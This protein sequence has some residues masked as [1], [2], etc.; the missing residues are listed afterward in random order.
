MNIRQL[1]D[2]VPTAG[3]RYFSL[4]GVPINKVCFRVVISAFAIRAQVMLVANVCQDNREAHSGQSMACK[5][6]ALDDGSGRLAA[7]SYEVGGGYIFE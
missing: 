3:A 2:A 4:D 6:Y 7:H 1:L 5:A